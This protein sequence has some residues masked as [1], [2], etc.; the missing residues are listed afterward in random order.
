MKQ[1]LRATSKA[2]LADRVAVVSSAGIQGIQAFYTIYLLAQCV[3][4]A[5]TSM[6]YHVAIRN[7]TFSRF[8]VHM[9]VVVYL[10]LSSFRVENYA[11]EKV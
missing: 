1:H 11:S 7:S 6:S 4:M 8:S 5:T 10:K 2:V 3:S 9:V